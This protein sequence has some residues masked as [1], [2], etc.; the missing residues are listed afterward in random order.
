ME[1]PVVNRCPL[2][3]STYTNESYRFCL[4]DGTPLVKDTSTQY[5]PNAKTLI[6]DTKLVQSNQP[7]I[8]RH[9]FYDQSGE[10]TREIAYPQVQGLGSEYIQRRVNNSLRTKFLGLDTPAVSEEESID[11]HEFSGYGV[12]LL[13]PQT[14]STK[15]WSSIDFGGAHPM[16]RFE[17]FNV[18]LRSG[19]NY[20]YEDL[21]R[22]ESNYKVT[23]PEKITT[24]LQKQS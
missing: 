11:F 20:I 16:N 22:M 17:A 2:C 3:N 15:L 9:Q 1:K 19:Y 21:F 23:I 13:T 6:L 18:D 12:T 10:T 14:L 24:S 8:I 7:K 4:D 5:D